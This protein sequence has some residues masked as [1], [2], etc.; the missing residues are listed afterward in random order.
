MTKLEHAAV[1]LYARYGL[2]E[3]RK[4]PDER[5]APCDLF[6]PAYIAAAELLGG[7][8]DGHGFS[9]VLDD[10]VHRATFAAPIVELAGNAYLEDLPIQQIQAEAARLMTEYFAPEL[11]AARRTE[12]T[13]KSAGATDKRRRANDQT[14][15]ERPAGTDRVRVRE[16]AGGL[17]RQPLE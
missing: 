17:H 9:D 12:T 16:G 4:P 5:T 10:E 8:E 15:T 11:V 2:Q 14:T 13:G 1:Q 6:G 3:V 7:D